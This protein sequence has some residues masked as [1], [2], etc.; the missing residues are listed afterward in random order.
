[1]VYLVPLASE[2]LFSYLFNVIQFIIVMISTQ[3]A[4]KFLAPKKFSWKKI[5]RK[6]T[7]KV[8]KIPDDED[9][10]YVKK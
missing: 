9:P 1:M 7:K 8:R 10:D 2:D 4:Y 6:T 5:I 3:F